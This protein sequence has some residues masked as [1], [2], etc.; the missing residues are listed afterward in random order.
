VDRQTGVV[1]GVPDRRQHR[2]RGVK[3]VHG[4]N[5]RVDQQVEVA[6]GVPDRRQHRVRGVIMER[7]KTV[8]VEHGEGVAETRV[9]VVT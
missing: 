2:V 4:K 1:H 6:R 9:V 7:G 3:T 8:G 5:Q